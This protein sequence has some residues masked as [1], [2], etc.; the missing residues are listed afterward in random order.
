MLASEPAF[1][2]IATTIARR[3]L[4]IKSPPPH[5]NETGSP[6]PFERIAI[7]F[8]P[9]KR[10]D[11]CTD[12][13]RINQKL[14]KIRARPAGGAGASMYRLSSR[15]SAESAN[16]RTRA[17]PDNTD[18]AIFQKFSRGNLENGR[19]WRMVQAARCL[20]DHASRSTT[21][22]DCDSRLVVTSSSLFTN[23]FSIAAFSGRTSATNSRKPASRASDERCR[24]SAEP[25]PWPWN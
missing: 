15:F 13:I 5:W 18:F 4:Q 20:K 2:A 17:I 6:R 12:W 10:V 9:M 1:A 11:L 8:P 24:K 3:D 22:I 23:T 7:W 25:I 14:S 21:C 16:I 19:I